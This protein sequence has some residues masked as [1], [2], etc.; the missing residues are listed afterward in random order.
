MLDLMLYNIL[1][2]LPGSS[3]S[4]GLGVTGSSCSGGLVVTGSSCSGGMVVTGSSCSGGLGVTGSSCSGGL[5]MLS[6][7]FPAHVMIM[8]HVR[9]ASIVNV[10]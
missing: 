3:C 4:G 6:V 2:Q 10:W 5:V 9:F 7:H 8:E 1:R